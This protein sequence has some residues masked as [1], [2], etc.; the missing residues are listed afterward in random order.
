VRS[1]IHVC[2]PNP[3]VPR[4]QSTAPASTGSSA[5][6]K[7]GQPLSPGPKLTNGKRCEGHGGCTRE[8][9]YLVSRQQGHR[10]QRR[11][12]LAATAKYSE[13][14][15]GVWWLTRVEKPRNHPVQLPWFPSRTIR[16]RSHSIERDS[17]GGGLT[18]SWMAQAVAIWVC[19]S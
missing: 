19:G 13:Q 15:Q 17:R 10:S 12:S 18:L 4:R 7:S 8:V 11:A 9:I 14:F 2:L 6:V 1:T 3:S 5:R 16:S